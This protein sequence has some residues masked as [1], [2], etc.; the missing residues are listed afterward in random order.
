MRPL[1]S[2]PPRALRKAKST[3]LTNPFVTKAGLTTT[4]DG[5]WALKLWLRRDARAPLRD[6]EEQCKGYQVLY[7]EEPDLL[8]VAWPAYPR[9][10][11]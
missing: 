3:A 4:E 6:V 11:D 5:R 7:A 1:T 9:R 2:T 8:P 10:G